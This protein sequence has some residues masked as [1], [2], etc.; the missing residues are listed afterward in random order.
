M[1]KTSKSYKRKIINVGNSIGVTLERRALKSNGFSVGD[2]VD[3][4]ITK[5]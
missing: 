1:M 5:N 3:V 4:V 2:E